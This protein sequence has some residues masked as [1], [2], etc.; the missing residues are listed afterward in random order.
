MTLPEDCLHFI[1][2]DSDDPLRFYDSEVRF[3]SGV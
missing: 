1:F 3:D 2:V